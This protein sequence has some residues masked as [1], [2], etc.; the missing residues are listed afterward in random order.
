M[1]CWWYIR[2]FQIIWSLKTISQLFEFLSRLH[3][4]HKRHWIEQQNIILRCQF[5]LSR[6]NLQQESIEN[7]LLVVFT[8][9]LVVLNLTSK[10]SIWFTHLVNR[11]FQYAL[12]GRCSIHNRLFEDKYFRETVIQEISVMADV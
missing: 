4:V 2:T 1:V 5:I 3:V 10:K 6:V 9:I 7:Q 11:C 8:P 12:T